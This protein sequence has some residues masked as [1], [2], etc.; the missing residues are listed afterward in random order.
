MSFRQCALQFLIGIRLIM[1]NK[2]LFFIITFILTSCNSKTDPITGE[3]VLMEPNPNKRARE[4]VNKEGS[5]L[6]NIT[7]QNKDNKGSAVI[8]FASSNVLWRA[9]LKTIDFI[10]IANLDYAGGMIIYDWYSEN[11]NSDEQIKIQIRFL[12]S[13][14][15]AD[16]LQ[17]LTYKKKCS[18][19]E[20]CKVYKAEDK[21]SNQ[22]KET[23]IA[24]ARNLKIEEAKKSK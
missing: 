14:L 18:Q 5:I 1:N 11:E 24:S 20:K 19:N 13:D 22:I 21:F 23:I 10:P 17:V 8:D 9:T 16:S 7:G 15:R 2:I 4:F 12:S 6:G 3:K